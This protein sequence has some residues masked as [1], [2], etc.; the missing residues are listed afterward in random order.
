MWDNSRL[1]ASAT[2]RLIENAMRIATQFKAEPVGAMVS[3]YDADV[4]L[5]GARAD[6]SVWYR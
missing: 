6:F 2:S 4:K 5:Y 3:D 1:S